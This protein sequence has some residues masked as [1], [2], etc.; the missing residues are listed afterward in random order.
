MG[1]HDIKGRK[2]QINEISSEE[3]AKIVSS[4]ILSYDSEKTLGDLDLINKKYADQNYGQGSSGPYVIDPGILDRVTETNY[5][6]TGADF[7]ITAEHADVDLDQV[8]QPDPASGDRRWEVYV[9]GE[10]GGGSP[11]ITYLYGA[12]DPDPQRPAIPQDTVVLHELIRLDDGSSQTPPGGGNPGQTDFIEDRLNTAIAPNTENKYAKIWEGNLTQNDNYGIIIDYQEPREISAPNDGSTGRLFLTWTNDPSKNI[13]GDTVQF[14]TVD[15]LAPAG[16]FVLV[17]EAANKVTL[18][19]KARQY[20][21][22]LEYRI[23][24]QNSVVSK[25]GFTDDED[26]VVSLPAGTQW[27]SVP[28]A[29]A[30]SGV[31]TVTGPYVDN[32]DPANP[33][34]GY[35]EADTRE[36][37]TVLFDKDYVIGQA[38]ARSGDVLIDETGAKRMAVTTMLHNDASAFGFFEDD[39]VTPFVFA[40]EVGTYSAG[41]DNFLDFEYLGTIGVR[42]TISQ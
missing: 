10:D 35:P 5:T 16:L 22:R 31:S 34:I 20:W 11:T 37:N 26:Y 42:L 40:Q 27:T 21:S 25:N 24:F 39:G 36:S 6:V 32:T 13:V 29:S 8:T 38:A 1:K 7:F 18:W 2:L 17:Q 12:D 19:H 33:V 41:T 23:T 3:V 30:A 28:Y 9:G 14:V 4:N 15:N